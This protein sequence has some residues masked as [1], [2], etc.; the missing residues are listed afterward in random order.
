MTD[1]W[2]WL[3]LLLG[4]PVG[5]FWAAYAERSCKGASLLEPSRCQ[6]CG[7]RL[8]PRDMVPVFSWILLRGRCRNC[9]AVLGSKLLAAEVLGFFAALLAIA[10]ALDTADLLAR[11][12]F[13]WLLLGLALTD[14]ACFRLPDVLTFLLFVTGIAL[15][16]LDPARSLSGAFGAG[17]AG[18]G[19]LLALKLAYR[20]LRGQDGL[21]LGDVKLAGGLGV[22]L[23]GTALPWIGLVGATAGLLAVAAGAFGTTHRQTALPFGA[24]LALAAGIVMGAR[25]VLA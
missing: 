12:L 10:G 6:S 1:P 14:L 15:A 19:V 13:L 5:S 20:R 8:A 21:G 25:T 3:V 22:A 11:A 7:V 2:V 23:G 9:G 4:G 17:L 24:F 18:A 16:L